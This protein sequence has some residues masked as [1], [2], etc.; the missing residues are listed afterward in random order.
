MAAAAFFIYSLRGRV[1]STFSPYPAT[2][3]LPRRRKSRQQLLRGYAGISS[4]NA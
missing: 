2:T 4:P 3:V 1:L